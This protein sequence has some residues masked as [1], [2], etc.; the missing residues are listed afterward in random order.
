MCQSQ[1]LGLCFAISSLWATGETIVDCV[2]GG[3][4]RGDRNI[5][6]SRASIDKQWR[7]VFGMEFLANVSNGFHAKRIQKLTN[8]QLSELVHAT[9]KHRV[10]SNCAVAGRYL[11]E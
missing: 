1:G 2:L 5:G 8:R 6:I 9:M 7:A 10:W 4:G 3:D 11:Y